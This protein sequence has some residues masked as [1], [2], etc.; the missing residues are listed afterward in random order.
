[1]KIRC[2]LI[3]IN[4][5]ELIPKIRKFANSCSDDMVLITY[6]INS[7]ICGISLSYIDENRT[8]IWLCISNILF[9]IF[10]PIIFNYK[11]HKE[12]LLMKGMWDAPDL[13]KIR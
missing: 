2:M 4:I 12:K 3:G 7:I 1:M 5:F 9:S 8:L 11:Y 6:L 10:Y 13:T